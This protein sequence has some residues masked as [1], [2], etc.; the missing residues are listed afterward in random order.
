MVPSLFITLLRDLNCVCLLNPPQGIFRQVLVWALDF[1]SIYFTTASEERSLSK[2][3]WKCLDVGLQNQ[4]HLPS[5]NWSWSPSLVCFH[6]KNQDV[7]HTQQLARLKVMGGI[8]KQSDLPV[9]ILERSR[10]QPS[11][12]GATGI[13][14]QFLLQ[15]R[16]KWWVVGTTRCTNLLI[17]AILCKLKEGHIQ[18]SLLEGPSLRSWDSYS[19]SCKLYSG[20]NRPRLLRRKR[21]LDLV[22]ERGSPEPGPDTGK[23]GRESH[24]SPFTL[25]VAYMEEICSGW[26]SGRNETLNRRLVV[27]MIGVFN[28]F[29]WF[30]RP[31]S[32]TF[33]RGGATKWLGRTVRGSAVIMICSCWNTHLLVTLWSTQ[34]QKQRDLLCTSVKRH[35]YTCCVWEL[36]KTFFWKIWGSK[37]SVVIKLL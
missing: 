37:P 26:T 8:S 17:S 32:Y 22:F 35:I 20:C 13:D 29:G 23:D 10:W 15:E 1:Q 21:G 6:F 7:S 30:L 2:S 36:L 27:R 16:W 24:T 3:L 5:G 11:G 34:K 12:S 31:P 4:F 28:R 18:F 25:L 9:K 14:V 19:S 33:S